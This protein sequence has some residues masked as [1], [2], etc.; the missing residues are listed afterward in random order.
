[1]LLIDDRWATDEDP[2]IQEAY[3]KA[4]DDFRGRG[5][6]VRGIPI[7][8]ETSKVTDN[9]QRGK[10]MW[11]VGLLCAL[12]NRDLEIAKDEV[13]KI[14]ER[15]R[16]GQA[17]VDMNH[18]LLDAGYAWAIEHLDER[19]DVPAEE[20]EQEMVVMNGNA[21]VAMGAMA[22]GIEV[23][24]M[25]P[26]TPATSATHYLSSVFHEAGGIIH[27]AEDEIAAVGFAIG[28]SYA[29]K[30]AITITS[31]PGMALKTEMLALAVMAEIP[32]VV[33]D[34]QRG[35]PSTGLPTKVE[36]G[37]LLS[38][39]FGMPGD[40]PKV[41]MA[42]SSIEECFHFVIT[43]RKLAE[44]FYT[45]VIVLTDA[46]LATG[47]TSFPDAGAQRGLALAAGGSV[48]VAGGGG[49]LRVGPGD[50]PLQAPGSRPAGRRLRAHRPGSRREE[51]HRLRVGHQP[52]RHERCAAARSR[53]CRRP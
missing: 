42:A 12:Y 29:G 6:D 21:A 23:C 20:Q 8:S 40:S 26:I 22:A 16:K 33:V 15:K 2:K 34:V 25:Y 43:A 1:M 50:G 5:Y 13:R 52:A 32:L 17:V 4:L 37:D 10:N 48:A 53:R 41:V 3:Q 31:G 7:H 24:S 11:V 44:A 46:N 49:A 9:P 38:S 35:G 28:A 45:P 19:F 39:I 47:Q 27:Q 14:F 36:Q 30:T 51:P 18:K